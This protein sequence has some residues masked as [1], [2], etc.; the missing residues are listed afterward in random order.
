MSFNFKKLAIPDIILIEPKIYDDERGHFTE[1]YKF[2]DFKQF[3]IDRQFVQVNH[4]RSKKNVLRGL[5]YQLKPMAQGKFVHAVVGKIFDVV[6][7]I[8]KG[9]P[10]F[11]KWVSIIL[12][13]ENQKML[14]VP[15]GF[16]HGFSVLSDTAEVI[17]YC[18]NEYA[19]E[20][21]RGILWDDSELKIGWPVKNPLLSEKDSQLP[22]LKNA[23]NNFIYT[24][25]A[26]SI[27]L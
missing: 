24:Q 13:S 25:E 3:G 10:W 27:E 9:S 14:Y 8:R 12:S 7:D 23:E 16:A 21:D 19:P 2:S 15:E 17:Y 11:G 6:V 18:T 26:V 20:Y 5:H 1:I 22:V 4:S